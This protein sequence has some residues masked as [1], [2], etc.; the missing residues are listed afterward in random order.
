MAREVALVGLPE[1]ELHGVSDAVRDETEI[2]EAVARLWLRLG[3][4]GADRP[5]GCPTLLRRHA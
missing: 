5:R 1:F 2:P 4:H 3:V